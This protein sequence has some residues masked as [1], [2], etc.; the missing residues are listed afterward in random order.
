VVVGQYYSG[1]LIHHK[2]GTL[3]Y[4]FGLLKVVP[5]VVLEDN[6]CNEGLPSGTTLGYQNLSSG[7]TFGNQIL[8]R[9]TT[10]GY[11]NLS[12]GTTFGYQNLSSGT[13]FG[14]QNL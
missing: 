6:I 5:N 13:T 12:S 11:Q 14:Y 8:S 9:G 1:L 4:S 10:F 7:T 2:S 3:D